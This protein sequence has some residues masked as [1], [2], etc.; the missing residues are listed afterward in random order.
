MSK[1]NTNLLKE[2]EPNSHFFAKNNVLNPEVRKHL[3]KIFRHSRS[4]RESTFSFELDPY[5]HGDYDEKYG[6]DTEAKMK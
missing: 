6:N 1:T 4:N 5:L 2:V 3:I